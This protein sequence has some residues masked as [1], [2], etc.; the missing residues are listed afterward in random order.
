MQTQA[1]A[2]HSAVGTSN[3]GAI[4]GGAQSPS[5]AA[6]A[7]CMTSKVYRVEYVNLFAPPPGPG[8]SYG[9]AYPGT[10]PNGADVHTGGY[11]YYVTYPYAVGTLPF[12]FFVTHHHDG[13]HH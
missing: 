8:Y 12:F 2:N 13:F 7:Q 5:D 10:Y 11:S 4:T 3:A 1:A 9:N 6:Y